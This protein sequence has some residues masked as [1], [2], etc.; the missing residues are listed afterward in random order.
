MITYYNYTDILTEDK[1]TDQA[2]KRCLYIIRQ[3]FNNASWLD[4]IFEHEDNPNNLTYIEYMFNEFMDTFYHDPNLRKSNT[5]R[6]APLFC[7]LAFQFN[8]QNNNPNAEVIQRLEEIL[9]FIYNLG[10]QNKIDVSKINLDTTYQQL[11]QMFGTQIDE[12]EK[13]EQERINNTEYTKNEEYQIIGP[14]DFDTANYYG[15]MSCPNSKLCYTQSEITWLQYTNNER[16]K[17]FIILKNGFENIEP[18]HDDETESPYDTYGTSMIFVFIN[19]MG[20]LVFCNTRWNHNANYIGRYS[21]DHAMSKE[22]INELIGYDMFKDIESETHVI[23]QQLDKGVEPEKLFDSVIE[24]DY[25]LF[26]VYSND[27][28]YNVLNQ[29]RKL[30]IN[31]FCRK[32][33]DFHNGFA[34]ISDYDGAFNYIN[35][36]GKV[37]SNTWFDNASLFTK[38]GTA[39]VGQNEKFNIINENGQ[40]LSEMWF[41]EISDIFINDLRIV[42]LDGK[43]E[44]ILT[45]DGKL[46]LDKW[47]YSISDIYE[48][49]FKIYEKNKG[50]NL[51]NQN[52]DVILSLWLDKIYPVGNGYYE[53]YNKSYGYTIINDKFMFITKE[54]YDFIEPIRDHKQ[55]IVGTKNKEYNIIDNNGN[56]LLNEWYDDVEEYDEQSIIVTINGKGSNILNTQLQLVSPIWFDYIDIRN[57]KN[58]TDKKTYVITVEKTNERYVLDINGTFY[59]SAGNHKIIPTEKPIPFNAMKTT[60]TTENKTYNNKKLIYIT[61]NQLNCLVE[62]V[63]NTNKLHD[64]IFISYGTNKFDVNQMRNINKDINSRE[65]MV[66]LSRNKPLGGLWASPLCSDRSWGEW[67]SNNNFR[68]ETLSTHFLFKIKKNSNI[69]VIDNIDDLIKIS[70]YYTPKIGKRCINIPY[71]LDNYDGIFVTSSAVHKLRI[72]D[73]YLMSDLYSWDVESICIWNKNIIIPIEENAFDKAS[74]ENYSGKKS[75]IETFYDDEGEMNNKVTNSRKKLQ[76]DNDFIKYANQNVNHDMAEY[77]NGEHPAILSQLHGNNKKTKQARKFNGTIKSG[78]K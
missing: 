69:Y 57:R 27:Y 11:E 35:S 71:L 12:L 73:D 53:A 10:Q 22:M 32:I 28:G 43:G 62:S 50:Y 42:E 63:I 33:Y 54:W 61:E 74:I 17:V 68:L 3:H 51:I 38:E 40:F 4:T 34:L 65:M 29:E 36:K 14:V 41:D 78:M 13:Q 15:N 39:K 75:Y 20:R 16:N 30:T 58:I 26:E 24:L 23:Q 19:K 60:M 66:S 45:K 64:T 7:K 46:L 25:G 31:D 47:F 49:C 6:L 67:C 77:F 2:K 55:F 1:R 59:V 37:I 18:I 44:N 21:C 8:F 76:M 52:C 56:I 70:D 48:N 72:L 9:F 5:M